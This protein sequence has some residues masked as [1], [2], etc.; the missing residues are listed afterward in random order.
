M[1]SGE[2]RFDPD[3]LAAMAAMA[4]LP[5]LTDGAPPPVSENVPDLRKF[6]QNIMYKFLRLQS[7]PAHIYETRIPFEGRDGAVI[8]MYRFASKDVA[9]AAEPQPAV[10]YAHGG[11][12]VSGSVEIFSPM[13][14]R[15]AAFTGMPFFA[16]DYRL[17]PEHPGPGPTEDVYNGLK[18]LSEHAS[19]WNIDPRRIAIFGESAGGGLAAGAVLMAR[20]LQLSPPLAKQILVY[21]MLDDR[22]QIPKESALHKFLVWKAHSNQIAWNAVLGA[23]KAGKDDA[24]VS[25]YAAPGRAKDLTGLP[26][27]YIDIGGLDLFRDETISYVARLSA[28]DVEV[29]FHLWPGLPH[30]FEIAD[31]SSWSKTALEARKRALGTI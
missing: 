27:T 29:E 23:D 2:L 14:I 22:T 16:V 9:E 18:H 28:A 12:M 5:D 7:S 1:S 19:E 25:I 3:Y 15:L 6:S 21:P 26:S 20:D 11:G 24:D 13:I 31:Q 4:A 10:I 8:N 17:A 30:A